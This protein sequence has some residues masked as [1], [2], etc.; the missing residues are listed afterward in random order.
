LGYKVSTIIFGLFAAA[1]MMASYV[2]VFDHAK[3]ATQSNFISAQDKIEIE[4]PRLLSPIESNK[5]YRFSF[6]WKW[7][8]GREPLKREKYLVEFSEDPTFQNIWAVKTV[9]GQMETSLL[10]KNSLLLYF[11]I[12]GPQNEISNIE[13]LE[14]HRISSRVLR[15]AKKAIEKVGSGPNLKVETSHVVLPVSLPDLPPGP[16][17]IGEPEYGEAREGKGEVRVHFSPVAEA[18]GYDVELST[19]PLYVAA[20]NLQM[21]EPEFKT[22]VSTRET[23]FFRVRA[24]DNM[25]HPITEFSESGIVMHDTS[26]PAYLTQGERRPSSERS[27][28]N[29]EDLVDDAYSRSSFSAWAGGGTTYTNYHQSLS[30]LG[31]IEYT[32]FASTTKYFEADYSKRGWGGIF[33]FAETPGKIIVGE[34]PVMIERDKWYQYSAEAQMRKRTPVVLFGRPVIVGMR[35]GIQHHENPF[36]FLNANG[37]LQQKTI[38]VDTASAGGLIQWSRGGW[39]H[40]WLLRYQTPIQAKADGATTLKLDPKFCF[41]GSV[42]IS[43]D[44]SEHLSLGAFWFGQWKQYRFKYS[45]DETSG[46]GSQSVLDSTVDLR[47][48]YQY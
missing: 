25:G 29:P 4:S 13:K 35:V 23:T 11:R 14:F 34:K 16:K 38:T 10:A 47:L 9:T 22:W 19:D 44:F 7:V 12:R 36:M 46:V 15:A 1:A 43:R 45:N 48:G 3:K 8:S 42:G 6:T 2:F 21:K 20:L 33:S 27:V 40:Y 26:V 17:I 32:N 39:S 41:D 18:E 5:P 28:L 30:G 31:N 37:D 24:L